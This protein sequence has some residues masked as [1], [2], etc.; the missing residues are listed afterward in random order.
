MCFRC[1][2]TVLSQLVDFTT[3]NRDIMALKATSTPHFKS[4]CS[5]HPQ[6]ADAQTHE[7]DA[8]SA[9]VDI[10]PWNFMFWK[11]FIKD[12]QF[13]IMAFLRNTKNTNVEGSWKYKFICRFM[14]THDPLDLHKWS[15]V[16]SNMASF[17]Q[18]LLYLTKLSNMVMV[19]T[20]EVMLGQTFKYSV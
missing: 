16:Q 18:S 17:F 10:R 12:E 7:M 9:P 4:F 15:M 14:E 1:R 8:K 5:S 11:I 19:Q 6:M 3:F 13:L 20:T 2:A